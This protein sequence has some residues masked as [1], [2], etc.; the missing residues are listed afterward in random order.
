MRKTRWLP[1]CR[2]PHRNG[3][4]QGFVPSTGS[5]PLPLARTAASAVWGSRLPHRTLHL[6]S[7]PMCAATNTCQRR[8]LHLAVQS[9][10]I[11]ALLGL[12]PQLKKGRQPVLR[13]RC[14]L[15]SVRSRHAV[16]A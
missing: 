8:L 16:R 1:R 13:W 6:G 2:R 14:G 12:Q 11:P 7:T 3:L 9:A 5:L 15:R 4:P 10:L